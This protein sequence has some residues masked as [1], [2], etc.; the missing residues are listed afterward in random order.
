MSDVTWGEWNLILLIFAFSAFAQGVMGFAFGIVAM[1]LLP[2]VMGFKDAVA[3]LAI[4]NAG[5][6]VCALYW[7]R[8]SFRWGD[9]RNLVIGSLV[10]IPIGAYLVG[11]LPER[12]LFIGLGAIMVAISINHFIKRKAATQPPMGKAEVIVGAASGILAAGFNM[13][14]P[15]LVAYIYS[16]NWKL[17]QAKAVLASCFVVTGVSRLAFLG[18]TGVPLPGLFKLAAIMLIPTV[19]MLRI[20]I[21]VGQ[22]V[23]QH[24]LRPAVFA[25]LGFVGAY[26][27]LIRH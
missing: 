3:L 14:G 22:S 19:L 5:V 1:T 26:Y 18:L 13:G 16:R 10:G 25:Y 15:P 23:P 6:M 9:A 11:A 20:G 4:L 21:K 2:W 17:D 7:Q 24:R 27:L 12:L 8:S